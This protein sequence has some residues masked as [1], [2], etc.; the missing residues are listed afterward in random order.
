MA[1]GKTGHLREL[2]L[3]TATETALEMVPS[4]ELQAEQAAPAAPYPLLFGDFTDEMLLRLGVLETDLLAVRSLR[5]PNDLDCMTLLQSVAEVVP[6]AAFGGRRGTRFGFFI[7]A[8][9]IG[10][11]LELTG[12]L[13]SVHC[14]RSARP[15]PLP[16]FFGTRPHPADI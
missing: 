1:H 10:T 13:S 7:Q 6:S 12:C 3:G 16:A 11:L 9:R 4:A 14:G 8:P 2:R 5:D 15:L